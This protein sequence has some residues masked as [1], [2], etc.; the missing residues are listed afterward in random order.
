V[1]RLLKTYVILIVTAA[2]AALAACI[3]LGDLSRAADRSPHFA[4]DLVFFLV[5][6]ILLDM[7][8]VPMAQGGSV[9]AGFAAFFAA[10]LVLG[11]AAAAIAAA[12]AAAST[13]LLVRRNVPL[14][15]T[16]F[17]AAHAV[18]AV[19]AA[20]AVY[21]GLLG[22]AMREARLDTAV[23]ILRPL[24]AA[25]VMFLTGVTAVSIAIALDRKMPVASLW[26]SNLRQ[27]VAMDACLAGLGLLVAMLYVDYGRLFGGGGWLLAAAVLVIPSG[28]LYYSS[29]LY[30]NMT[31]IYERTLETLGSLIEVRLQAVGVETHAR[32]HGRRV[33]ELAAKVA[34]ELR[35]G[36]EEVQALKY[37]GR[38]HEIGKVSMRAETL[39]ESAQGAAGLHHAET[40]YEMLKSIPFLLPAAAV[41]RYHERPFDDESWQEPLTAEEQELLEKALPRW[42]IVQP[43]P[44]TSWHRPPA[45]ALFLAGQIL[46]AAEHFCSCQ[47]PAQECLQDMETQSGAAFHPLVV[48]A[49]RAVLR[50][51]A[52]FK[53]SAEPA[54][55][56]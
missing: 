20:G 14:R 3:A 1:P 10:L 53:A 42:R 23:G 22:G 26:L 15:K 33:A 44:W 54:H 41:V 50:S 27:L 51:T 55:A 2:L 43:K 47:V 8:I 46:R 21:Y 25:G 49:M 56:A 18:L 9:S 19:L 12:V 36:P 7:L 31:E 29:H 17:N 37:A 39:R 52:A 32:G 38:L 45:D 28:L 34:E 4:A 40:G 11:P 30:T 35:L 5:A 48:Q 6:C 13:D 24:L 16:A